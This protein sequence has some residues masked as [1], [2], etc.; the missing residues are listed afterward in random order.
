[1]E[2]VEIC[3]TEVSRCVQIVRRFTQAYAVSNRA[4]TDSSAG[5]LVKSTDPLAA[6]TWAEIRVAVPASIS[7]LPRRS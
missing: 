3:E 5:A 7:Y 1:M 4:R 6:R 2:P